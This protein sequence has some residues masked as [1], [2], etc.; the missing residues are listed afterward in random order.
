MQI[1]WQ[2]ITKQKFVEHYWQKKPIVLKNAIPNFTD[3]IAP[4]ELAGLAME[5]FVESR[6]ITNNN[7]TWQ[8][9]HG[10]F[11]DFSALGESKSTL[12]VQG[13]DNFNVNVNELLKLVDFVPQ[14]R[15]D[16]VMISYSSEQ[17]GVGAHIDQYDVFIIQGQGQ[18]HWQAGEINRNLKQQE[19]CKDLMQVG[20]FPTIVDEVLEPGDII[21][22]PP[23]SP[24]KG[25]TL[26]P[27]LNYSIGFR[28]PS[29]LELL[30]AFA[31]YCIDHEKGGKRYQDE[32]LTTEPKPFSPSKAT[33]SQLKSQLIDLI[34][35][36]DLFESFLNQKLTISSRELDISEP[37]FSVN[38]ESICEVLSQYEVVHKV[39]GLKSTTVQRAG[40]W[41]YMCAGE[42]YPFSAQ[43]TE[44]IQLLQQNQFLTDKQLKSSLDCL[45]NRQLLTTLINQGYWYFDE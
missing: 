27:A 18:R 42:L 20:D 4:E 19:T 24:H 30:S 14:W 16:D 9:N 11:N 2:T 45:E 41:E 43:Q 26:Q 1:N 5:E 15:V 32:V 22:I 39:L 17:A 40:N 12:L 34:E 25:E 36:E 38:E 13:V 21:Y 44:F 7:G 6:M 37:S 33:I 3:P 23:F 35:Q 31:D 29:S 28:A 10:P 8:V